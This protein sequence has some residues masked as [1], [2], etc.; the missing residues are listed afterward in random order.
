M[1][2]TSGELTSI[3][4]ADDDTD[5]QEFV[6]SSFANYKP[7]IEVITFADGYDLMRYLHTYPMGESTPC[8]I[9]VD[10]NMPRFDGRTTVSMIKDMERFKETPL[11]IFTTSSSP[12]DKQF[13]REN[14]VGFVTKPISGQQM[15]VITESFLGFCADA[16]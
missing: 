11:V 2:S 13:A 10:M 8:L 15:R 1:S 16:T 5:D 9:I 4:Y 14:N 12:P 3:L 7:H 6:V